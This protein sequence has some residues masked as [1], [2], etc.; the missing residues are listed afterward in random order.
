[1]KGN[2]GSDTMSGGQK[3]DRASG[4]YGMDKLSGGNASDEL[5]GGTGFDTLNGGTGNDT[6]FAADGQLD[7]INC[8]L[9]EEDVVFVDAADIDAEGTNMQEF[10]DLTSCETINEPVFEE[11]PLETASA[12]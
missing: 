6:V 4:G 8:G 2:M 12:R 1:M 11:P 9:G 5:T 7:H 3:A 10:I